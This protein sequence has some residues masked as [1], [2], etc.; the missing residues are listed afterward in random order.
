MPKYVLVLEDKTSLEEQGLSSHYR[1]FHQIDSYTWA[2][3]TN[4]SSRQI[5]ETLFPRDENGNA[6][7]HIVLRVDAWWGFHNRALWEWFDR[8]EG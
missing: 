6:P 2:I 4:D 8:K 1:V 5:S 7:R 3:Q